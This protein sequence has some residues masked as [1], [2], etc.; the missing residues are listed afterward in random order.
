M[1]MKVRIT[2]DCDTIKGRIV[3]FA[4]PR[5]IDLPNEEAARLVAAGVAQYAD[6]PVLEDP[7]KP[8]ERMGGRGL[9][10]MT[11]TVKTSMIR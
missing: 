9:R 8:D 10:R 1:P 3:V 6:A 5:E 4:A 7:D 2:E 11:A